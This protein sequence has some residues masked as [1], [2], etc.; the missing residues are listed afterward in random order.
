MD[1][2]ISALRLEYRDGR[3][4]W[5]EAG[6]GKTSDLGEYRIP[7]LAP[8]QYLVKTGSRFPA[9]LY[10]DKSLSQPLPKTAD[11][12]YAAAYHPGTTDQPAAVPVQVGSGGEVRGVDIRLSPTRTFRIRGSVGKPAGVAAVLAWSSKESGERVIDL[13]IGESENRF[14]LRG[15]PPGTYE[16]IVEPEDSGLK[17]LARQMVV[18]GDRHVDGVVMTLVVASEIHGT[19]KVEDAATPPDL[20]EL[21]IAMSGETIYGMPEAVVAPDLSFVLKDVVPTRFKVGV[22]GA[23]DCCYVKSIRYGGERIPDAGPDSGIEFASRSTLEITLS[24]TAAQVEGAVV[25]K[26]GKGVVGATVALIPRGAGTP[27]VR[28]VTT[29]EAG[30][31]RFAGLKPGDYQLLAWEDIEPGA[32]LDPDFRKAFESRAESV[33]LDANGHQTVQ[34]KV[35][36]A[37]EAKGQ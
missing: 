13:H 37:E 10:A 33:T 26:D 20:G 9:Y 16:L 19:V 15:M 31:Y 36:S 1:L 4:Q 23:P 22:R 32:C 2:D 8:G 3:R 25:D 35:I 30:R 24:A 6:T 29:N 11:V 14:E 7:K 18:V 17:A 21:T 27:A 5:S 28:S 12:I 34:L